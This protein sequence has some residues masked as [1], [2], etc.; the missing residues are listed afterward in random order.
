MSIVTRFAVAFALSLAVCGLVQQ[1]IMIGVGETNTSFALVLLAVIVLL[2]ALIFGAVFWRRRSARAIGRTA[3]SVLAFA[4]VFGVAVFVLGVNTLSPGIG[5]NI[6][7]LIATLVVFY[8]LVPAAIA[9]PVHWLML[10]GATDPA[11]I[12]KTDS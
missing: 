4:L 10:R 12:V 2:I 6:G 3:A 5:G 9:V 1:A 8:F 7:Y 11:P